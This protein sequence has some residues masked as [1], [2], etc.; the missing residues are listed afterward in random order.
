MIIIMTFPLFLIMVQLLL[1]SITINPNWEKDILDQVHLVKINFHLDH[2]ARTVIINAANHL[3]N[4]I[5]IIIF[6]LYIELII[7]ILRGFGFLGFWG[8][9]GDN[10]PIIGSHLSKRWWIV[11]L[12]ASSWDDDEIH[13]PFQFKNV[14]GCDLL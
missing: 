6:H 14:C 12:L 3:I 2:R 7:F 4:Y 5:W 13:L 8:F 9:G 10:K 11:V 1:S